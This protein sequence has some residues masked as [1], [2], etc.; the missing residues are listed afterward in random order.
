MQNISAAT[1]KINSPKLPRSD[2]HEKGGNIK[3]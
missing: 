2:E 1:D 3:N